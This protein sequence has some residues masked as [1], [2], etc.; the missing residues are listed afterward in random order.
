MNR[1]GRPDVGLWQEIYLITRI[2]NLESDEI[3]LRVYLDPIEA[4]AKG[5][6]TFTTDAT[7]K[8]TPQ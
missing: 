3:G 2:F 5:E 8:V 1:L 7:W 4:E 6:L